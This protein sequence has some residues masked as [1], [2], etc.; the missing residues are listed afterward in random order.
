MRVFSLWD[1]HNPLREVDIFVE[2]PVPFEELYCRAE[3]MPVGN[4]YIRV[5]SIADLIAL[6]RI[7]G[8]PAD[9]ADIEALEALAA[10]R[11]R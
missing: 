4:T 9:L 1:P 6:K 5:A 2:H 7:A 10:R 8:R 3:L 11:R